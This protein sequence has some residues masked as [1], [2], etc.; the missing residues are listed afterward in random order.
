[1][2]TGQQHAEDACANYSHNER[3]GNSSGWRFRPQSRKHA[4][5]ISIDFRAARFVQV[6]DYE[7]ECLPQ[8][9][10]R[11]ATIQC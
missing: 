3:C 4:R 8:T 6:K 9:E 7:G 11:I 2:H 1:V 5:I 10:M